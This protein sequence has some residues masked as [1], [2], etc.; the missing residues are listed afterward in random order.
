M[1]YRHTTDSTRNRTVVIVDDEP[2]V[3]HVLDHALSRQGYCCELLSDGTSLLPT[4]QEHNPFLV[5]L[6]MRLRK[7]SGLTLLKQ[8]KERFPEVVVLI[9]TGFPSIETAVQAIHLGA[10]DYLT[11]PFEIDDVLLRVRRA[12]EHY[13]L[14]VEN[15]TLRGQLN[16]QRG[17]VRLTGQ[18]RAMLRAIDT[19]RRVAASDA[20]ILITGES[21]TGKELAAR[22]IHENS[23]RN[24]QPFVPVDCVALPDPLI[25]SELFGY[26]KGAFTGA[27]E[28]HDGLFKAAAG[29]TLLL[30][31]ITELSRDT[32]AKL[33]RVLQEK[34]FRRV[35]GRELL[36]VDVR[37][38]S[39]TNR[40]PEEAVKAGTFRLDL[41]YRL[42]VIPVCMPPLRDRKEDIPLLVRQFLLDRAVGYEHPSKTISAGAL[43]CLARHDWPGNV[44]ELEN[45]IHRLDIM[46]S[47][48]VIEAHDVATALSTDHS[49]HRDPSG[50]LDLPFKAAKRKWATH[51]EREYLTRLLAKHDGV[52]TRAAEAAGI[53]RKTITRLLAQLKNDSTPADHDS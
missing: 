20:N 48:D 5:M 22:A 21:G 25:T 7:D 11:K 42:N 28:Q 19:I 51:F 40:D 23:H 4:I 3:L 30:D 24:D 47:A 49:W 13:A 12:W 37:I 45:L 16:R 33:L 32:Q 39:A 50:L 31:E 41:Y 29:G 36:T 38:I 44:R 8:I 53:N 14:V 26:E 15:R 10:L 46:V 35:G 9:M 1:S 52:V 17:E 2:S 27:E 34:Q 6:D 43:A 18:S